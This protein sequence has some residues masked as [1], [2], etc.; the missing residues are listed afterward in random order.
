VVTLLLGVLFFCL[1]VWTQTDL[2]SNRFFTAAADVNGDVLFNAARTALTMVTVIG[3]GGAALLAYRR[4]RSTED[5]QTTASKALEFANDGR[6]HP[7][8]SCRRSRP[9]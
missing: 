3:L 9:Q 4:Q 6:S 2:G 5:S 7:A 1:F 8:D